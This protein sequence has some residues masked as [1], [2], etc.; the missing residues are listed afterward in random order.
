MGMDLGGTNPRTCTAAMR[1]EFGGTWVGGQSV[2]PAAPHPSGAIYRAAGCQVCGSGGPE[3]PW[4][5]L[6]VGWYL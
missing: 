2:Y 6:Q 5:R 1:L 4:S 3:V